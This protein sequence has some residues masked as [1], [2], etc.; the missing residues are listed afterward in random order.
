MKTISNH[1]IF[2]DLDHTLL[3]T[4][5]SMNEFLSVIKQKNKLNPSILRRLY[6]INTNSIKNCR[7]YNNKNKEFLD[8]KVKDL[9]DNDLWGITRPYLDEFLLF[10]RNYFKKVIVWSAGKRNYVLSLI[11]TLFKRVGYYPDYVFTYDHIKFNDEGYVVKPLRQIIKKIN[12]PYV[13][14]DNSFFID[15]TF[16][17]FEE[18]IENGI[19]IPK[20]ETKGIIKNFNK[21]DDC[22]NYLM[23]WFI[24]KNVIESYDIRKIYKKLFYDY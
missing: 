7:I 9:I 1:C 16:S 2:L 15:D 5:D 3:E 13:R 11:D 6:H 4:Q 19:L 22:L 12:D 18:N 20:Y 21:N 23:D 24:E 8:T 14:I 10:C 17:T